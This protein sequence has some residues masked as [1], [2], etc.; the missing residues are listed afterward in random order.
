MA[1]FSACILMVASSML[2]YGSF[3]E[4]GIALSLTLAEICRLSYL[5]LGREAG[6]CYHLLIIIIHNVVLLE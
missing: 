2:A 3:L 5:D 4:E 1:Q 6:L